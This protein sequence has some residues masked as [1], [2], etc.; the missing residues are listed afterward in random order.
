[1]R[2]KALSP[3][4]SKLAPSHSASSFFRSAS[5]MTGTGVSGTL[6]GRIL[7]IGESRISPSSTSVT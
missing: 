3:R 6:G 7:A 2:T 5:Q 1:M 4:S